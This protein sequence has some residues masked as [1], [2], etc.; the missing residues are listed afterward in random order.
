MTEGADGG[1][2]FADIPKLELDQLID[3]LV[4]R[5]QSVKRA[6][7]RLRALLRA[8]ELISSDLSLERVLRHIAEAACTL[9]EARYAALGVIAHDGGLEQ[10]IHVGI[11]DETAARIGP[12]PQG[13]GLLGALI[14]DP[15]A[16]RL[17]RLADDERSAGFPPNHPPMTSFLGVPIRVRGEVFGNLYLTES[18]R[19]EFSAEDEE[20]VTSLALAA[21]TAI[22]NARLYHDS[23]IQQRWLT[24]SIGI[25]AQLLA[26]VGEDPLQTIARNA[27]DIADADLVSVG[28]LTPEGSE[29]V[30]EVAIGEQADAVLGR[31]YELA[32]SLAGKAV[33]DGTPLLVHSPGDQPGWVPVMASEMDAGPIMVIPL[34]GTS[35]ALGVL[36]IVRKRGS[37]SFSSADLEMAAA[38]ASQASVALELSNARADQQRVSLLED[39]DRIARDLH[40]HVIQQLFA[41]GLSLQGLAAV[42]GGDPALAAA[43]E[44]RVEDIDRT[45]RQIRTSIFAL[46]GP[47]A[48]SATGLRSALLQVAADVAPALGTSPGLTFAGPVDSMIGGALA[49]DVVAC[50]REGLTN[51]AKYASARH[52]LVDVAAGDQRVT[53]RI[54]D[55][56]RGIAAG[57]EYSGLRNLRARAELRGGSFDIR[58]PAAGGTELVWK[59]PI[60]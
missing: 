33:A 7:D 42:A 6:Q 35:R 45:I 18:A 8:T 60:T 39:R 20:L 47:L 53:I 30:V 15:Q 58:T 49:D 44:D 27:S 37:A 4:E 54:S 57:A 26:S 14:H 38:F 25:A 32:G 17:K 56:G 48:G 41:V 59:A 40:D 16:I 11:D 55:D 34:K 3:Q 2:T 46:R 12:L 36:N 1:L 5:A 28:I 9:A 51:A 31:R 19:G 24:A 43:L 50:V 21:G 13:K 10:F 23:R 22:S 52:V 29:M